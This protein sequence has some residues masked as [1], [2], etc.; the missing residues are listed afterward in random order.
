MKYLLLALTIV[1]LLTTPGCIFRGGGGHGDDRG[2]PGDQHHD[3]HPLGG[4][5][6]DHPGDSDHG[7][8]H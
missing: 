7:D 8:N 2:H 4:D 5:H 6:G 1:A 3:D